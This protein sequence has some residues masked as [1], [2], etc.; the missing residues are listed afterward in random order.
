[1]LMCAQTLVKD[2]WTLR[3]QRVQSKVLYE[4][5]T[6]TE[7]PSSQVFSSQ[8]ES[9]HTTA[10]RSTRRSRKRDEQVK[11][12]SPKLVETLSLCYIGLLLLRIPVTVA[13]IHRWTN[14]ADLLY[15]RA[16]QQVPLGMRERLPP[17]YQ[18]LLEPQDLLPPSALHEEVLVMLRAFSK[19]AG[20]S[21]PV[22]NLPLVLYRWLR[23]LMLPVE[24]YAA[25]QRLAEIVALKFEFTVSDTPG[26]RNNLQYPET[27]LMALL[28]VATKLLFPLDGVVRDVN[29]ATDLS[30]ICM[31]WKSWQTQLSARESAQARDT[32]LSFEQAFAFGETDCFEA[33]DDKL[34]AYL[35][36]YQESLAS[37]EIRT[38]GKAGKDADL[39]RAL[40]EMFPLHT[41]QPRHD[42]AALN[43]SE[44]D[45][46]TQLQTV[47]GRVQSRGLSNP[48]SSGGN[49]P[50]GSHYRRFRSAD[51]LAG[52]GKV[53]FERA[54]G[55]A[56]LS[57]EE[58]VQAV[59]AVERKVQKVEE[60]LRK[61][62]AG[63]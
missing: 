4:S 20:M 62:A 33:A 16:V 41:E 44:G 48:S 17:R 18:A 40:F 30:A 51:E 42:A 57:V 2:L 14:A 15:Y 36:W 22:L 60:K 8:S 5:E 3:L 26:A 1:M 43:R 38:R 50:T 24:I 54:A 47:Q 28:V 27:R 32:A 59:L 7:A 34:D 53:F 56:G 9:E 37:E 49:P 39:R 10:S 6:D 23:D 21:P 19:N 55:L 29:T 46:D 52:V 45:L 13:D 61:N 31:D 35:D 25:T 58:M 63:K 11:G 12:G